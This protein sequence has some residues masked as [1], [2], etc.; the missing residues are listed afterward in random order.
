MAEM[1]KQV[2][3]AGTALLGAVLL[4]LPLAQGQQPAPVPPAPPVMKKGIG[5]MAIQSPFQFKI[6][7]RTAP[8]DLLPTPPQYS[9][10]FGPMLG[11]DLAQVPEI[12]FQMPFAKDVNPQKARELIAH[13]IAKISHLNNK[14][15]TDAFMKFLVEDRADLAGLP[16]AMGDTCRLSPERNEFFRQALSTLRNNL[17]Q[18][19]NGPNGRQI[20]VE[21]PNGV[22]RVM[23]NGSNG[24]PVTEIKSVVQADGTVIELTPPIHLNLGAQQITVKDTKGAQLFHITAAA[25]QT[26]EN[27]W[28]MYQFACMQ[29]DKAN[30]RVDPAKQEHALLARI[31]ALVQVLAP[32][33]A[34]MRLGLA[35]YLGTLKHPEATRALARMALYSPEDE[36]HEAAVAALKGRSKQ[37]YT[38]LLVQGLSYPWPAVARRA[39]E[40]IVRLGRADLA[41]NLVAILEQ[42][43]P[44]LPQVK[45]IDDKEVPV[46]RELVRLNHHQ[47]CLMC[48]SPA[49]LQG[50]GQNA[51]QFTSTAFV[52]GNSPVTAQV[53]VPGE[54]L[55]PPFE[56]YDNSQPDMLIRI[57]VT[58]LRQDFSMK[59]QV[60]NAQ[61]WPEMQRFDFLVRSRKLSEG[62]AQEFRAKLTPAEP[63]FLSPYQ[64]VALAALR[65][66]T[67]RDTEPNAGAWR[68]L[69]KLE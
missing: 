6:D 18:M 48:H 59:Q 28:Q 32:E 20:V 26:P 17:A 53:P 64:R 14:K 56:G 33:S 34:E 62:E 30:A 39:G 38:E 43:D 51:G 61:P 35:K 60:A 21:G 58:Y 29:E 2:W 52:G 67:G 4:T 24:I 69:L 66:L 50:G 22:Q 31:A 41:P 7:P 15:G 65:D 5:K 36:V 27:F 13:G 19:A 40:A 55:Q 8:G 49:N 16:M 54:P 37:D 9:Q 25:A 63:G 42:V 45:T 11:E 47:N 3:M 12:T 44:R 46:V 68:R 57:D 1:R 10:R 23:V